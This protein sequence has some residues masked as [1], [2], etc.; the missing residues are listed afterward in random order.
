M[1]RLIR[2]SVL[3]ISFYFLSSKDLVG[4]SNF[5]IAFV[6]RPVGL[7]LMVLTGDP[8]RRA[9]VVMWPLSVPK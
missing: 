4:S 3:T 7:P 6:L 8:P 1:G 5:R 2:E 9:L